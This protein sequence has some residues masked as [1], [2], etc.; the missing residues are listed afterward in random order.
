MDIMKW[1]MESYEIAEK[2]AYVGIKK[3]DYPS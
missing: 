1:A 3:G 2:N